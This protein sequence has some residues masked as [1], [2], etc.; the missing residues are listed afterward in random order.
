MSSGSVSGKGSVGPGCGA[1][2]SGERHRH[3]GAECLE[4]EQLDRI[5]QR[6]RIAG[7]GGNDRQHLRDPGDGG[8]FRHGHADAGSLGTGQQAVDVEP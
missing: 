4:L 7:A 8:H 3:P 2:R 6:D 5:A 1:E